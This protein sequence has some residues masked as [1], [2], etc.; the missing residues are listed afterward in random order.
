MKSTA[1][2]RI[3]IRILQIYFT[4]FLILV[5]ARRDMCTEAEVNEFDL[6]D[7]TKLVYEMW[8]SRLEFLIC[9]LH[10]GRCLRKIAGVIIN[11]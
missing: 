10:V 9:D 4:K 6:G 8:V 3:E 2:T 5:F 1:N 11:R 7:K